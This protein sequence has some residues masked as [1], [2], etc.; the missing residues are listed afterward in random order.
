MDDHGYLPVA[1]SEVVSGVPVF[2]VV[3]ELSDEDGN[4][5]LIFRL[6]PAL[7]HG[8]FRIGPRQFLL[9]PY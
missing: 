1:D 7:F 9:E 3:Q 8:A 4:T 2:L 6:E 5:N